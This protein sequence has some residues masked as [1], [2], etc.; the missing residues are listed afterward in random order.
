MEYSSVLKRIEEERMN[1]N[2]SAKLYRYAGLIKAIEFFSQRLSQDQIV[3]S[4]FDFVNELLTLERSAVFLLSSDKYILRKSKGVD[5]DI[6]YLA[7]NDNLK[8][9]PVLHGTLLYG[10]KRLHKYF[11]KNIL[12]SFQV[13]IVIPLI[14]E[15]ILSGF[16]FISNKT[17]GE[18][19][20]EDYIIAEALMKLFNNALENSKRYDD[21]QEVNKTL[22]EKIF[23]LF[24][25]NQSSKALLS[26]LSLDTLYDLSVDVFSELTQSSVTGFILYDEMSETYRVKAFKDI[27]YRMPDN[28]ISFKSNKDAKVD[29]S[30]VIIDLS[31]EKDVIYFNRLFKEGISSLKELGTLYIVMLIKKGRIL[32]FVSLG[33]TTTGFLYKDSI[34]ELIESLAS[35]TYIAL[36]NA[37]LFEEV[38]EQK[39]LIQSKL[40][41][42]ISLNNLVKNINSSANFETLLDLTIKTMDVAFEVDKAFISLYDK[43]KKVL[44]VTNKLNL[45]IDKKE[46]KLKSSWAKV[47]EGDMVYE[48]TEEGA[49]KFFDKSFIKKIGDISGV[50]IIPIFIE[51]VDIEFIG[52][53]IIFK[54]RNELINDEENILIMETIANHI[55]PVLNNLYTMEEQKR[56]LLPNHIELFKRDLKGEINEALEC[57]LKLKVVQVTNIKDFVFI[58]NTMANKLREAYKKVYPLTYNDT[59]IIINDDKSNPENEIKDI[60]GSDN[61][62]VRV[63]ELGKDFK[64]YKEFFEMF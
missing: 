60:L 59:F 42:L 26:E 53:L 9:V 19:N 36:S 46:V 43:D 62:K 11:E 25:I 50:L 56:F 18:L 7:N 51:R 27:Y 38:S 55:A 8:N 45:D 48:A 22:D 2:L 34:F 64:N 61:I 24:A 44:R 32:G 5:I 37:R 58:E 33:P 40:N 21:L 52:A 30:K 63:L 13:S 35:A 3:D 6:S 23:N 14:T 39:K 29:E 4:A 47:L 57:L 10:E 49:A 16:I 41:K 31:S 20:S 15:N 1:E 17:A 54:F 28:S 12:E